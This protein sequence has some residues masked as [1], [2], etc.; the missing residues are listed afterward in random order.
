MDTARIPRFV[1]LG[2]LNCNMELKLF[3]NEEYVSQKDPIYSK[4]S[5]R[6]A[7]R[8]VDSYTSL[9]PLNFDMLLWF[10]LLVITGW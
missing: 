6:P 9:M 3:E 5:I 2:H 8:G 1:G 10:L 4:T 7:R